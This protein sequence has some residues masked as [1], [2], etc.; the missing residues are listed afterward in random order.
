MLI[1][2]YKIMHIFKSYINFVFFEYVALFVYHYVSEI[3]LCHSV[4]PQF[5]LHALL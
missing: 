1:K 4:S 5:F 2:S 3:H